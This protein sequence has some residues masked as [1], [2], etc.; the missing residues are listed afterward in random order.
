LRLKL[1]YLYRNLTRNPLRALLTCAAVALP[2]MIYVLSTAVIDG[3]ERYLDNS[4]K[5]LRLAVTNKASMVIPLPIAYRAKIE[6]LDPTRE[7]ILAVNSLAWIGGAVEDDPRPLSTLAVDH[8]TFQ[9]TFNEYLRDEK[10]REAWLRS[11]RAIVLGSGTARQFGWKVGD[12]ITIRP[13]VP[14]YVP[15]EFEVVSTSEDEEIIDRITNFCRMDYLDEKLKEEGFESGWVN[16]LFLKCA[17]PE[18]LEH[19][20]RA[21]DAQ[22][23]NAVNQTVTLD[24]KT[25]MNQFFEQQ[26]NLSRNL[27][28]LSAV[29]VFVAIMAAMNTMSMNLRDRINEYATL[30]ALGFGSTLILLLVQ[31]ESLVVCGL[32]GVLGAFIPY[33][34]FRWSPLRDITIPVIQTLDVRPVVCMAAVGIALLV[35]LVAGL[36]PAWSAARLKVVGA[37][38][39]LE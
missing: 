8:D 6:A 30:R 7:R 9:L 21:V 17:T 32:G 28:I 16:N 13:S 15:M 3:V 1:L 11:R 12:R 25:F 23:A 20:R 33:A 10:E 35:G 38:R 37:L 26:F 4:A 31:L 18:D 2:I 24:E 34:A 5:Q 22:F 14:P 27:T 19:F 36:W 29:T 39:N